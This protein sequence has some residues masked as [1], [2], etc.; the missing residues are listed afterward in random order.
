MKP[1]DTIDSIFNRISDNSDE[2]A[3]RQLFDMYAFRLVHFANVFLKNNELS[4]EA[5]SDVFFKIWINRKSIAKIERKKSYLYTAVRNTA[6]NYLEKE[7]KIKA[8]NLEDIKV[9]LIVDSICP[10]TALIT[11]E[12]KET[13]IKAI[14][15]LPPKCKLIYNLA[16]V[17]KMK[18]KEMAIVLNISVKTIDNQ[19]AIALKKIA[20]TI[21]KHLDES[22]RN[23]PFSVLF[24][25]FVPS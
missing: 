13:I 7:K 4:E 6:L 24:Q 10:E 12:L 22:N 9:D 8:I 14:N 11:K 23:T 25:L 16:K 5:V 21:S 19:V 1:N 3:F 17:E 20:E 15:S 2:K 18:Y